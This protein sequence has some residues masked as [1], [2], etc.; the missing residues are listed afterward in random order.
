MV[1]LN[2]TRTN[3]LIIYDTLTGPD[4][5]LTEI[6]L[7]NLELRQTIVISRVFSCHLDKSYRL[8]NLFLHAFGF[9][10]R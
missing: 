10:V 9:K 2:S 4:E 6:K 3:R 8:G 5:E 7:E 1:T